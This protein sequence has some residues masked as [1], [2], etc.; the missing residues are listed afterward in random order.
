MFFILQ[1]GSKFLLQVLQVLHL[2]TTN[3]VEVGT[4]LLRSLFTYTLTYLLT[5]VVVKTLLTD[6]LT[7]LLSYLLTYYF[8]LSFF[9]YISIYTQSFLSRYWLG[10]A[11]RLLPVRLLVLVWQF[12]SVS[13][14]PGM[15]LLM[16]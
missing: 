16:R 2:L 1:V 5:Y 4:Y 11:P 10:P 3:Y 14:R 7:Y 9:L 6:L 12:A 13:R 8:V 15:A